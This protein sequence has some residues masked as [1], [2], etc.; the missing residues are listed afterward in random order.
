M[1][2]LE[3]ER[4]GVQVRLH[5]D[6]QVTLSSLFPHRH[7]VNIPGFA[8][9]LGP[10]LASVLTLP[11]PPLRIEGLRAGL[12]ENPSLFL[13]NGLHWE[14]RQEHFRPTHSTAYSHTR[15]TYTHA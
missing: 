15:L 7:Q 1:L 5:P 9:L 10:A 13:H 11:P 4:L 14:E 8:S 3:T 6:F 12:L 2:P